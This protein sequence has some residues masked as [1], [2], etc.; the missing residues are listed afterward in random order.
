MEYVWSMYG[1][2][3]DCIWNV[4]TAGTTKV[5]HCKVDDS[6]RLGV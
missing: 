6:L 2:Y 4:P 3:M 5:R 1:L